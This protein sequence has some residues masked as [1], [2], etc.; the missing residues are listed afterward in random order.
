MRTLGYSVAR[1]IWFL[2]CEPVVVGGP[3]VPACP[4][5]ESADGIELKAL[6]ASIYEHEA[7]MWVEDQWRCPRCFDLNSKHSAQCRCGIS[8]DGLPEFCER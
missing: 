6:A 1:E 8:R 2:I 7:R 5:F 3:R 4:I